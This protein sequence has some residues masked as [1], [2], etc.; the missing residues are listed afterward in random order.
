MSEKVREVNDNNFAAEV[1]QAHQP[2]LVDFWAAW[3]GPCLAL[4]PTVEALAE[5]YE[6]NAKIVKLNVD[7]SP[8]VAARY[9]IRGIPTLV[10]FNNG[11]EAERSV[12]LTSKES[13]SSLIDR[14]LVVAT[15]QKV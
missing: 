4:A 9:G 3:C 1:L 6:G 8:S 5:K 2:V 12:G 10:L 14:H 13:L 7:E 11:E 15:V